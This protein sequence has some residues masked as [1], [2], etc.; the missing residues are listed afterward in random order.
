MGNVKSKRSN[1]I[2]SI[3]K[4]LSDILRNYPRA[5]LVV[6]KFMDSSKWSGRRY[7]RWFNE[8]KKEYDIEIYPPYKLRHTRGT[9]LYKQ[10]GDIYAVSRV[11]GHSSVKVTE[12]NICMMM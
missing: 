1:C 12:K 3:S 6:G 11:L 2:L 9:L 8:Q 7:R 4:K 5:G 10:T